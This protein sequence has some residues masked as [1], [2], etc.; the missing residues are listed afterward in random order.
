MSTPSH[1]K[2]AARCV[3]CHAPGEFPYDARFDGPS[4]DA[5]HAML[6]IR[7]DVF[8]RLHPEHDEAIRAIWRDQ[9]DPA[10]VLVIGRRYTEIGYW[11]A[12]EEADEASD[13][14]D[15]RVRRAIVPAAEADEDEE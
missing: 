3:V 12:M 15:D 5:C 13:G 4:C 2:H 9:H 14:P 1:A 10:N 11:E 7:D 8:R 6:T